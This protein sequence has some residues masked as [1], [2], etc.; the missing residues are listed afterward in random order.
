LSQITNNDS[1]PL[2]FVLH[3]NE[4]GGLTPGSDAENQNVPVL[5]SPGEMPIKSGEKE[6]AEHQQRDSADRDQQGEEE[7]T[8]ILKYSRRIAGTMNPGCHKWSSL[9]GGV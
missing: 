5:S 8:K 2:C 7:I 1:R 9:E 4:T 6:D 3:R